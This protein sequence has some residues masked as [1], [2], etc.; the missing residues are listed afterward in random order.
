MSSSRYYKKRKRT[1][2][3][4]DTTI[5]PVKPVYI[6]VP[7]VIVAAV[8]VLLIILMRPSPDNS[9]IRYLASSSNGV[10]YYYINKEENR[11]IKS[12]DVLA[13]GT[14]VIDPG[15][16]YIE[17]GTEYGIIELEGNT[18]YINR[19]CLVDDPADII[20]EKEVW[21][22][23]S[24]TV[25]K[26][27]TGPEIISFAKKGD[28]LHILGYDSMDKGGNINKYKISF[29]DS[30]GTSVTGWVYGKYMVPDQSDSLAVNEDIYEI[31]KNRIYS[32]MK[33]YG[34]LPTNLDWY[35]VDKPSFPGNPI[36]ENA[37]AMYINIASIKNIDDYIS[38][39]KSSDHSSEYTYLFPSFAP[40][41]NVGAYN[42]ILA[43]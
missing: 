30:T 14:E 7:A 13:R 39:A 21:V 12:S 31:H 3:K 33:L 40:S 17:N 23:T 36:C 1:I 6:I 4:K 20:Q 32:T 37:R 8:I 10:P 11:L 43:S 24:A 18:Y 35:P 42:T 38:L 29:T 9:R 22:R 41:R 26:N 2:R 19:E 28:C 34:G 15:R 16:N 27:E 25:Y 5:K